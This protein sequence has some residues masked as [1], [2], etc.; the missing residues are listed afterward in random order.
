[1]ARKPSLRSLAALLA[2]AML[3]LGAGTADAPAAT[4]KI[5]SKKEHGGVYLFG[6]KRLR[7][8][9]IVR[10][11]MRVGGVRRR[12]SVN[13]VRSAAQ[14]GM[15]RARAPRQLLMRVRS[16]RARKPRRATLVVTST[17]T[18]TTTG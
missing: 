3:A 11:E 4:L 18:S 9:R 10:A 15:F 13:R 5:H 12:V 8:S 2:A 7:S 17:T 1:M 6:V 16:A 14:A